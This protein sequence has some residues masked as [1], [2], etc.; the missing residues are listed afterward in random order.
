MF[1]KTVEAAQATSHFLSS[2]GGTRSG[3][4]FSILQ[5]LFLLIS[6]DTRPTIN[7]VVSQTYP[8][9]EKGAIRDFKQIAGIVDD[10]P[11]WSESKHTYT[12]PNGAILEFFSVE[13]PDRAHGPQRF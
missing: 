3:K 12:F 4:T 1:T 11:R 8:Q 13:K 10:D 2:C 9:L 5:F 7:S 6:Q